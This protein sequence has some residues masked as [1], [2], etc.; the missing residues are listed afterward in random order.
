MQTIMQTT[1]IHKCE[2]RNKSLNLG[3]NKTRKAAHVLTK[4]NGG[5]SR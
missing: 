1:R 5:F 2:S 4:R 3:I